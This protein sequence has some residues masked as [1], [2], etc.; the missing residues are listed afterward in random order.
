MQN[1]ETFSSQKSIILISFVG[2]KDYLVL[3][4]LSDNINLNVS[5]LY[6]KHVYLFTS[7]RELNMNDEI[8]LKNER[9]LKSAKELALKNNIETSIIFMRNL[10]DIKMYYKKIRE[11]EE[12]NSKY[13]INISAGPSAFSAAAMLWAIESKNIISYSIEY[14]KGKPTQSIVFNNI[15]VSAFSNLLLIEDNLEK[16]II[17]SLRNGAKTSNDIRNFIINKYNYNITIR[18]IQS[19]L[20]NLIEKGIIYYKGTKEYD[21]FFSEDLEKLGVI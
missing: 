7:Q 12:K 1:D 16:Y 15:D 6:I 18:S 19:H 4:F 20:K 5:N 14:N 17:E 10:W 11:L 2:F 9:I 13:I 3:K 8:L 21:F